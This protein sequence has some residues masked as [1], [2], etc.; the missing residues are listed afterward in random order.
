M[1]VFFMT[2]TRF[3][4]TLTG[5]WYI[6]RDR[7]RDLS[8]GASWF[9]SEVTLENSGRFWSHLSTFRLNFLKLTFEILPGSRQGGQ[10]RHDFHTVSLKAQ[11]H[12][13]HTISCGKNGVRNRV[14]KMAFGPP[15]P[16][17]NP[18]AR[19]SCFD[20]TF[21]SHD[22][23]SMGKMLN[24]FRTTSPPQ[25]YVEEA[26]ASEKGKR[27]STDSA[28]SGSSTPPLDRA[29]SMTACVHPR[30]NKMVLPSV[31]L[32]FLIP[33]DFHASSPPTRSPKSQ[34][35]IEKCMAAIEECKAVLAQSGSSDDDFLHEL[36]LHAGKAL[37]GSA[38][39]TGSSRA[40]PKKPPHIQ[41][42]STCKE[43]M[44]RWLEDVTTDC[45]PP[46]YRTPTPAA[47]SWVMEALKDTSSEGGSPNASSP[48]VYRKSPYI[49]RPRPT[50][51]MLLEVE[52]RGC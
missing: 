51:E 52:A 3:Y 10:Q 27:V 25:N 24:V 22:M 50:P 30:I 14:V 48:K 16:D 2:Q 20:P 35:A 18:D 31:S 38:I 23:K 8:K 19:L 43:D 9:L 41:V 4:Y 47:N 33:D 49:R 36:A 28:L 39:A 37:D 17:K 40:F 46:T 21:P 29:K 5:T 42:E 26:T 6:P 44:H 1:S 34:A 13:Y 7:S 45:V 32:P 11:S 15:A 12:F